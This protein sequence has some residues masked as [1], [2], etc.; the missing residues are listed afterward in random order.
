M[1]TQNAR[2]SSIA[3]A[4]S[5]VGL[6]AA[7]TAFRP[8]ATGVFPPGA[9]AARQSAHRATT[10]LRVRNNGFTDRVVYVV[11]PDGMD[12]RLGTATAAVTTTFTIPRMFVQNMA[13][14]YFAARR[15]AGFRWQWTEQ[16]V[17]QRGDTVNV[18]IQPGFGGLQLT[19][20]GT[21]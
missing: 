4:L 19:S 12:Q 5:L 18:M 17:V 9:T 11:S 3:A 15:F 16:T 13:P 2:W 21:S 14:V 6:I 20:I 7:T 1:S 10:V 8:A